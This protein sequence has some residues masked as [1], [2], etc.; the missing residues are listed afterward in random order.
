MRGGNAIILSIELAQLVAPSLFPNGSTSQLSQPERPL[1]VLRL[2]FP[3]RKVHTS[4]PLR[5]LGCP[6]KP[7]TLDLPRN[8]SFRLLKKLEEQK[9]GASQGTVQGKPTRWRLECFARNWFN[10]EHRGLTWGV[11]GRADQLLTFSDDLLHTE[12]VVITNHFSFGTHGHMPSLQNNSFNV[13]S[14]K[15]EENKSQIDYGTI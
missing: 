1:S 11:R 2:D 12:S 14:K 8:T 5:G 3:W 9:Q 7:I 4:P 6:E 15:L 13:C 10:T